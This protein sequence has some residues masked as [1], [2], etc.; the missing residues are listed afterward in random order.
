MSEELLQTIIESDEKYG[1]KMENALFD[2]R[3]S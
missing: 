3:T 1:D 2:Q